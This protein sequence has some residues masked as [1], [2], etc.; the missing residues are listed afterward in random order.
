MA[1]LGLCVKRTAKSGKNAGLNQG[2][3]ACIELTLHMCVCAHTFMVFVCGVCV[4]SM[5]C[6]VC[7]VCYAWHVVCVCVCACVWPC[8]LQASVQGGP[9]QL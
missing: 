5:C 1:S 4:S 3:G 6:G 7:M 8:S 2:N 9:S